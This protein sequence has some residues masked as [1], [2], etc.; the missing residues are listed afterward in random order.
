MQQTL[1]EVFKY[2]KSVDEGVPRSVFCFV[3][4]E[5]ELSPAFHAIL[6]LGASTN[7]K[8]DMSC[9]AYDFTPFRRRDWP[10]HYAPKDRIKRDVFFVVLPRPLDLRMLKYLTDPDETEVLLEETLSAAE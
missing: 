3:G 9:F 7:E 4:S 1:R 8:V 5:A 2:M 6:A 10:A